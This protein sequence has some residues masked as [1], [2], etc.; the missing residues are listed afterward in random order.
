MKELPQFD[1][2]NKAGIGEVRRPIYCVFELDLGSREHLTCFS[3]K[4]HCLSVISLSQ[5]HF[6]SCREFD[7]YSSFVLM[8]YTIIGRNLQ[9]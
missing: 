8:V 5:M 2:R 1:Y 9:C 4:F 7:D 6:Q 3:S